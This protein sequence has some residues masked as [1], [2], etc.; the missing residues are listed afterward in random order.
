MR[1]E[2]VSKDD[3]IGLASVNGKKIMINGNEKIRNAVECM[4]QFGLISFSK[5]QRF[6]SSAYSI[7][8]FKPVKKLRQ[9]YGLNNEVLI[10]CGNNTM[11]YFASRTKDLV[12]YILISGE[13]RNRLD[14]ITVFLI[15]DCD[16]IVDTML[17]DRNDHPE[18]RI[19]IPFSYDEFNEKFNS[20]FLQNRMRVFMYER[21]LFSVASPLNDDAFFFGKDRQNLIHT[22]FGKYKQGEQSGLFGLRRIGKTSTLNLLKH[23]V[24][25]DNGAVIYFDCSQYHNMRWYRVLETIIKEMVIQFRDDDNYY[26]RHLEKDFKIIINDFKDSQDRYSEEYA[27]KSFENNIKEIYEGLGKTRILLMFDEIE[28]IGYDTSPTKHWKTGTDSLNFWQ[29]I[30]SITQKNNEI[31]SFIICGVNPHVI[32]LSS[33]KGNDNPIFGIMTPD[34]IPLFEYTDVKEM[35]STIG[36]YLGVEFDEEVYSRL[37]DDYGGHPF[38]TRQVCSLII[39]SLDDTG[40]RP[41]NVNKYKYDK[42]RKDLEIDISSI[43]N[44]ILNVL[45]NQYTDEFELLK[46]FALEGEQSFRKK[47]GEDNNIIVHLIGYCLIKR[48]KEDYCF[49]IKSIERHLKEKY[50]NEIPALTLDDKWA[51]NTVRRNNIELKLRNLIGKVY[52]SKY[53]KKAKEKLAEVAAKTTQDKGQEK[54]INKQHGLDDAIQELYFIQLKDIINKDYGSYESFLPDKTKFNMYMEIINENRTDAHAKKIDDET[55]AI[56]NY[57]YKNMEEHLEDL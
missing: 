23:R 2:L 55:E 18:S 35:V 8:F 32:E 22:F 36:G 6:K 16:D 30:R 13:Y 39:S 1:Y 25:S 19:F 42:Q 28:S 26:G 44:Q 24:E 12:D 45:E 37:I 9:L 40:E 3:K 4:S 51:K 53:G 5:E 14:R 38:L 17:R 41:I 50:K 7:C 11:T 21:D 52:F 29:T 15:D 33:I 34:Y 57:A 43:I 56:L 31:L 54:R 48:D 46:K 20:E 47:V 27:K 49:N 10:V